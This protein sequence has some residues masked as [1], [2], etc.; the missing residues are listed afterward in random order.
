MFHPNF[1]GQPSSGQ[2]LFT[3]ASCSLYSHTASTANKSKK[4]G[5]DDERVSRN[6]TNMK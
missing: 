5:A 4:G 1:K 6:Q 2:N 3:A